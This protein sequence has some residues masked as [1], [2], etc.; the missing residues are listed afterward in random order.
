V[1]HF[2]GYGWTQ[3]SSTQS[4]GYALSDRNVWA[5][6]GREAG[7]SPVVPGTQSVHA[8]APVPAGTTGRDAGKK[9]PGRER[10]LAVDVP[11][12]VTAVVVLAAPANENTA[13][14]ALL[15]QVAASPP[16]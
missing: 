13:G 16:R 7:P 10:G 14:I 1:F 12:L 2:N 11:G 6:S 9:V 3:V 5:Y 15:D 8:A 4:G